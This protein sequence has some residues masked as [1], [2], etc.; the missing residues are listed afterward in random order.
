MGLLTV[1]DNGCINQGSAWHGTYLEKKKLD[2]TS[3][4]EC[5]RLVKDYVSQ[6]PGYVPLQGNNRS[7][8]VGQCPPASYCDRPTHREQLAWCHSEPA[9]HAGQVSCVSMPGK[10][11]LTQA[12]CNAF[13]PPPLLP[14]P[15]LLAAHLLSRALIEGRESSY[16][17]KLP[18]TLGYFTSIDTQ[19]P[20]QPTTALLSH[21]WALGTTHTN[22]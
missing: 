11:P 18:K 9:K 10:A 4:K 20:P 17:F 6:L 7:G 3:A 12:C 5:S 2:H 1:G 19:H 22:T 13:C 8:P 15:A 14:N 16:R 21:D